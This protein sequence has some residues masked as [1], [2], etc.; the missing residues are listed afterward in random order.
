MANIN[1]NL[2]VIYILYSVPFLADFQKI[3]IAIIKGFQE[4][5]SCARM[6]YA[7]IVIIPKHLVAA[8]NIALFTFLMEIF[9]GNNANISW[10]NIE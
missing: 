7:I 5:P 10:Q 6:L 1:L 2:C 8:R 3:I 4:I 9:I